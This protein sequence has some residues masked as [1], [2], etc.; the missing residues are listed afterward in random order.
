MGRS[1]LLNLLDPSTICR[2]Y[3]AGRIRCNF[4]F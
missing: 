1:Q 4:K 3:G 2:S